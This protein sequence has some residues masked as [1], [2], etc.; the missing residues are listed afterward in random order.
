MVLHG[1][2]FCLFSNRGVTLRCS[3]LWTL[4]LGITTKLETVQVKYQQTNH[5][6]TWQTLSP[7]E[8]TVQQLWSDG[9]L[10]VYNKHSSPAMS[11]S[12]P[13]WA[14]CLPGRPGDWELHPGE[15][16]GRWHLPFHFS[17]STWTP[18]FPT[19]ITTPRTIFW[20]IISLLNLM[21][22][23]IYYDRRLL[24]RMTC[25]ARKI[26]FVLS[27]S[28]L[29]SVSG[30]SWSVGSYFDW[31]EGLLVCCVQCW[32]AISLSDIDYYWHNVTQWALPG[33][34]NL[35]SNNQHTIIDQS[36]QTFS[37]SPALLTVLL[38]MCV[39]S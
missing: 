35:Y 7:L 16:E 31:R 14:R 33:T 29:S 15:A 19:E 37:Y 3:R 22:Y 5:S 8:D 23:I 4:C 39:L 12:G 11:Q 24:I 27:I 6:H 28:S 30:L 34:D 32:L 20:R 26:V 10:D 2:T 13:V 21:E 9:V 36:R 17:G 25:I 38:Q 18:W 1:T